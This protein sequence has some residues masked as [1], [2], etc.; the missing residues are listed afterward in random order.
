MNRRS[1]IK[2]LHWV[3][4]GL[5]VY[6]YLVEPEENRTDPGG[7]LSTHSGVGLVLAILTAIWLVMY[8]RKGL[9]GRAGPKLP[10]MGKKFHGLNHRVLQIGVPIMVG[11]GALAGLL[12][13]YTIRAFGL[14]PINFA[15]GNKTLHEIAE[16]IHEIAFDALIIVIVLHAIFHIWRHIRLKDNALK[17]MAPKVLH[18][19]L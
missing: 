18:K 16:E 12:A 3:S 6:F 8:L 13:P 2:W 14:V 1:V 4:L 7:A 17:I 5:I 15:I 10:E 9:A 11:T 19:Y